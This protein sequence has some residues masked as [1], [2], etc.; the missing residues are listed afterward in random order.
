M[1][2]YVDL[3]TDVDGWIPSCLKFWM[4]Y[5]MIGW[6]YKRHKLHLL[7]FLKNKCKVHRYFWF[8]DLAHIYM[9]IR[10]HYE[11]ACYQIS[12][13]S[14]MIG[15][16]YKRHKFTFIALSEKKYAKYT[17]IF[18]PLRFRPYLQEWMRVVWGC[19]LLNIRRIRCCLL[20]L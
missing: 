12:E 3:V 10:I 18:R 8:S 4:E 20:K 19:L 17:G 2:C 16:S 1:L 13:E 15:W 6:S 7:H 9:V 11:D 14:A 5:A